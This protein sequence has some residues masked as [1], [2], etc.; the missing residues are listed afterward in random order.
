MVRPWIGAGSSVLDVGCADGALFGQVPGIGDYLGIDSDAPELPARPGFRLVRGTF[1]DSLPPQASF[2]VVTMLAV[3][4]HVPQASHLA[5]AA[6]CRD[7][8]RPGGVLVLTVPGP[9]V[10]GILDVLK[11]LRVIDGMETGQHYGFD[12]AH[13]REPFVAVGFE[14]LVQRRFQ[15]GLNNLFAFRRPG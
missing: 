9:A 8:L 4:E 2:D 11:A 6:A 12:P 7:C 14:L 10:D 5:L 13:T 3:L 1:P 15:L